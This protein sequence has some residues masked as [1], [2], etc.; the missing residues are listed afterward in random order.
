MRVCSREGLNGTND[1]FVI[2]TL[3]NLHFAPNRFLISLD[4][5]FGN[6]F[7]RYV[8]DGPK[9]F[10]IFRTFGSDWRARALVDARRG[11]GK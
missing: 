1:V 9:G 5:L 4:L 6:Y 10:T 8:L 7:E 11:D 2:K 3:E